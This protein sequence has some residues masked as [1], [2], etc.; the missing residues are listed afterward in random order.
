M[1]VVDKKTTKTKH[2]V[3]NELGFFH[4]RLESFWREFAYASH[5]ILQ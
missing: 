2:K 5:N 4:D 1:D 3:M